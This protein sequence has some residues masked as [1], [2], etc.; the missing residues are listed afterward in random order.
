MGGEEE[1]IVKTPLALSLRPAFFAAAWVCAGAASLGP[2]HAR[3]SNNVREGL[4]QGPQARQG[5]PQQQS[6]NA[7][8]G[9]RHNVRTD[10]LDVVGVRLG[11]SAAA[12]TE[13]LEKQGFAVN[14]IETTVAEAKLMLPVRIVGQTG[15]GEDPHTKVGR[16]TSGD[17]VVAS[18]SGPPCEPTAIMIARMRLSR[19][20]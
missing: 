15:G 5:Q 1:Q 6:A 16:R 12:A 4:F 19:W 10:P 9:P 11:M 2:A 17:K 7:P 14:V 3:N 13:V 20:I 8:A 18:L